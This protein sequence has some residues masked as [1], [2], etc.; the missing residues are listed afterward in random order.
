M[1]AFSAPKLDGTAPTF[2]APTASD[3]AAVGS[4]L[5]VKNGSAGAITV[6]MT[7]PKTLETGDAY[8][9]KVHTIAAGAERW[10]PVLKVYGDPTTQLATVAF[11]AVASVTAAVVMFTA[12]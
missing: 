3:T 7:P 9:A 4:V 5:I 1:Q 2:A 10:I 12:F 11:S 6:T 8:P